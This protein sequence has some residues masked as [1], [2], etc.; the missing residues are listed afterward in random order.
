MTFIS[1]HFFF[2]GLEID[3]ISILRYDGRK[4]P[5]H[6]EHQKRLRTQLRSLLEPFAQDQN[7]VI[8]AIE[9]ITQG[10]GLVIAIYLDGPNGVSVDECARFSRESGVLLDVEDPIQGAYTLE[11]SSPGFNRL[12]ERREDFTRF[13]SFRIRAKI[14]Q[15]KSKIEGILLQSTEE[16]FTLKTDIDEREIRYED[17][18]SVRLLPTFEQYA[19][20]APP[21][22]GDQNET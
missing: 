4:Q 14:I 3:G 5:M 6:F 11:V 17:C 18:I 9:F 7:L 22:L 2:F 19:Q 16:G 12:L 21:Q 13:T 10:R 8:S 15:R 1:P 20:L